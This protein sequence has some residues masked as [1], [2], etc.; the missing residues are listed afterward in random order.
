MKEGSSSRY[1]MVG[2][3][4]KGSSFLSVLVLGVLLFVLFVLPHP[5]SCDAS[6][7]ASAPTAPS[8]TTTHQ[9]LPRSDHNKQ[10][11][12]EQ[13]QQGELLYYP[14]WNPSRHINSDGF[15]STLYSRIP[16]EWET[17]YQFHRQHRL[18][19]PVKIRQVPGDGNCLFHSISLCLYYAKNKKQWKFNKNNNGQNN[20]N[21]NNNNNNNA[22]PSPSSR[23]TRNS[24]QQHSHSLEE[25]YMSSQ[26]LRQEAVCLLKQSHRRL[27]LQGRE[28]LN[29]GEL[30]CAAAQQY[31]LTPDEYC[32]NM[33]EDS[34][35]GGGP[36]IVALSN[37]LQRPIHV[38]ELAETTSDENENNVNNNKISIR[39]NNNKSKKKKNGSSN[40][41]CLRRMAC[42]GSPR[43]DRNQALCILSADSRFPDL[44]PGQQLA[45]GNHFLALF[46][47]ER[48]S[49]FYR[50]LHRRK[51]L[52]GGGASSNNNNDYEDDDDD[53][54]EDGDDYGCFG[55][56]GNDDDWED[57]EDIIGNHHHHN[58]GGRGDDDIADLSPS[59]WG[60]SR[61][62]R[63]Q[64]RRRNEDGVER[65][66]RRRGSSTDIRSSNTNNNLSTILPGWM[67][68]WW[69]QLILGGIGE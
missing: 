3:R 59:F 8:P 1:N 5:P 20:Q 66:R 58:H 68:W 27:Y 54:E 69:R 35:W 41:F 36:E 18:D 44:E 12:R 7:S 26:K 55:I 4:R 11:Q 67:R 65:Q 9:S 30:V 34:V 32:E 50:R 47:L 17:P 57:E 63:Q 46:P 23:T 19:L 38:Y 2:R 39:N 64:Q 60:I 29:A 42:F 52:R 10:Q 13:Q 21:N 33:A 48:R 53:Y 56:D 31:N 6:S 28:C 37:Y 61:R 43:F 16:G 40:G 51:R 25:L 49:R 15:L 62:R 45:A 22:P 14:P 24:Q